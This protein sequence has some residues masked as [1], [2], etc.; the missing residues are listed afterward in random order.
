MSNEQ[1]EQSILNIAK[2]E[3][4]QKTSEFQGLGAKLQEA[5]KFVQDNQAKLIALDGAVRQL[6]ELITRAELP[7]PKQ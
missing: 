6:Q 1:K 5:Q 3:L 2:Q 4:E 7:P